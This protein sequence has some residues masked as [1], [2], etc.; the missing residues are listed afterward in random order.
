MTGLFYC[1]MS[2]FPEMVTTRHF[3]TFETF[4]VCSEF[5]GNFWLVLC[6]VITHD[7]FITGQLQINE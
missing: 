2:P 6:T 4:I 7:H 1:L 5:R 3:T